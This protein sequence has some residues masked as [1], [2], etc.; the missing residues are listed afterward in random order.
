[1]AQRRMFSRTITES[2]AFTDMPLSTQALYFHLGLNADDDG[3]VNS[4]KHVQRGIGAAD[5]DMAVLIAKRFLIPFD[6][7]VVVIRHWKT[8]N[9]IRHDRYKPTECIEEAALLSDSGSGVY[10]LDGSAPMHLA[11]MPAGAL[12]GT[13][14]G[15]PTAAPTVNPGK[16]RLG[17]DRIETNPLSGKA[18]SI[19][20]EAVDY[21]N[22]R[23]GRSFKATSRATVRHVRARVAEGY[24]IEDF[25][26]VIDIKTAQWESDPNMSRYLRPETLFGPKFE[27]YLNEVPR[28]EV[29]G[30]DKYDD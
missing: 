20:A 22:R 11:G 27:S 16:D 17:K 6:S 3:F 9:Y 26:R 30:Y 8:N 24:G 23:T 18:A 19:A 14:A 4:P 2:D 1:M 15:I 21:L 10:V 28:K 5:D 29:S 25:K 7:G 12:P 13:E